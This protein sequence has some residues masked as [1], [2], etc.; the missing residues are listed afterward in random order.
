MSSVIVVNRNARLFVINCLNFRSLETD[1]YETRK[2][3]V[4][5]YF[6]H[7][8]VQIFFPWQIF[9]ISIFFRHIYA[10]VG[11]TGVLYFAIENACIFIC[12][13]LFHIHAAIEKA[14]F[15]SNTS[16]CCVYLVIIY[17]N[18]MLK[19][20]FLAKH[21]MHCTVCHTIFINNR[22]KSTSYYYSGY[23]YIY[24]TIYICDALVC[25]PCSVK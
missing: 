3:M 8:Y 22:Q 2:L 23:Y 12:I 14:T 4:R 10:D 21:D 1:K 20:Y 25:V 16:D 18:H 13:F 5:K 11:L 6:E 15:S 17:W 24:T 7:H 19:S 9:I